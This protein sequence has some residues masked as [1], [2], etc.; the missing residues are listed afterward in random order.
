[1]KNFTTVL[2]IAPAFLLASTMIHAQT[3]D[4]ATKEKKI[5]EVVLIGYGKQ[6]KTDLTGSITSV[7]AK[8]FNGGALSAGQLIQGKTPGVQITNS[9]GAPGSG[10]KI[11][12]RGTS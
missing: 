8:D 2:K 3:K 5:E 11:R 1:M 10:T 6:K 7:T 9:S 12:I 4:S